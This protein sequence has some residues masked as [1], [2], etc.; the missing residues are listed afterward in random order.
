MVNSATEYFP[1][2]FFPSYMG[3]CADLDEDSSSK[4]CRAK[5][6]NL[7]TRVEEGQGSLQ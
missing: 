5:Y 3:Q 7:K 2:I 1:S 6:K 4:K